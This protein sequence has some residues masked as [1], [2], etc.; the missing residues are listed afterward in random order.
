MIINEFLKYLLG[1]FLGI[2]FL[3]GQVSSVKVEYLDNKI[4]R[5]QTT[6]F[7]I[8]NELQAIYYENS[9]EEEA[10]TNLGPSSQGNVVVYISNT[11]K[12]EFYKTIDSSLI[13]YNEYIP[14]KDSAYQVYD[15]IP[16]FN[17]EITDETKTILG[18]I[19]KKA[20][21]KFRGSNISAYFTE[22]IPIPFGPWKFDGLPGLILKVVSNDYIDI[23]WVATSIQYPYQKD[24]DFNLDENQ[25]NMS[26]KEFK[27][28]E[29]KVLQSTKN[30]EEN[31]SIQNIRNR[32]RN[33]R[34][35]FVIEQVYAWEKPGDIWRV[36]YEHIY[37][38]LAPW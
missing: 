2:N 38:K 29:F 18:F 21:A 30:L 15:S 12:N 9:S 28:E 20:T 36:Y 1:F 17:W 24:F 4:H 14:H 6:A 31:N 11:K 37:K 13:Y 25:Y 8:A 3:F 27:F 35:N 26:L 32:L 10:T 5:K 23:S 22:E 33:G 16:D 34:R 7:L 19:C